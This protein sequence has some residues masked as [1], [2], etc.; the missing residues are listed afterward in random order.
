MN[1]TKLVQR[2]DEEEVPAEL[3]AQSIKQIAD[4]VEKMDKSGLTEKAIVLLLKDASG[5]SM[6]SVKNALWGMRNMKRL[7]LK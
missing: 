2:E 3:V 1:K 4:A 7:Y 5:E 6:T